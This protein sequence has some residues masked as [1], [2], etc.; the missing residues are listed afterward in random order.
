MEE[1]PPRKLAVIL[2]ADVVG[3]TTLVQL[4]ETLAHGRIR[5]AFRRLSDTVKAYGGIAHELRGDALVAQ[6]E[7]ASDAVS[8]ALT[9]QTANEEFNATLDDDIKPELRIGISMGEVVIA[10]H[11]VTGGGVVLAQRLEQLAEAGGVCIQGAAH[12]TVPQRLP[13]DYESLGEHVVK[14]FGEPV[15]AYRV[16]LKSGEAVPAPEPSNQTKR[17]WIVAVAVASLIT[18]VGGVAWWQPWVDRDKPTS[19]EPMAFPM[20]DKASIAVLAFENLSGDPEQGYFADAVSDNIIT[21]L[22]RDKGLFVIARTSSFSYKGNDVTVQQVANEL[23][24]Q[25]VLEGSVQRQGERL[26]VTAQ[27]IDAETGHHLW[28]ERY[29][30]PMEDLFAVQDDIVAQITAALA[31]I[32][33]KVF[34][35]VASRAMLKAPEDM[36]AYDLALQAKAQ[37]WKDQ[38]AIDTDEKKAANLKGLELAQQS[39]ERDPNFARSHAVMA[40]LLLQQL[41]W[42]WNDK[43]AEELLAEALRYAEKAKQLDPSD[44]YGPWTTGRIHLDSGRFEQAARNYERALVLHSHDAD[45]RADAAELFVRTGMAERGLSE[46]TAAMRLN[47]RYLPWYEWELGMANYALG[48][49]ED[50]AR[51]FERSKDGYALGWLYAAAALAQL[52]KMEKARKYLAHHLEVNP[53]DSVRAWAALVPFKNAADQAPFIEGM[54]KAGMPE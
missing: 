43:P 10:D 13:F 22:S 27:F 9:F 44:H 28:A 6:F 24:V 36:T 48:R 31:S 11:T 52:G 2:H 38:D 37:F 42:G 15:R 12:E 51:A 41:W 23:G 46:I 20:S 26:R 21:E 4:N 14:G 33:G 50:A 32:G 3:S 49:Y 17:R 16:T 18:G 40:W 7:R 35:A 5:D 29:D 30:R 1:R 19:I 54:R 34:E 45:L 25:Y 47:P 39:I 8:T 53:N